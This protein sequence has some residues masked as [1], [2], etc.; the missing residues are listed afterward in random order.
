VGPVLL[1]QRRTT[2]APA[3]PAARRRGGR[4]ETA[5]RGGGG[6]A[7]VAALAP[8]GPAAPGVGTGA[9]VGWARARLRLLLVRPPRKTSLLVK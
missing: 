7:V 6:E 4:G 1:H 9:H 5:Q 3:L 2:A 8:L